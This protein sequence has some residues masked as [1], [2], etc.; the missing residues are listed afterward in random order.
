MGTLNLGQ[1]GQGEVAYGEKVIYQYHILINDQV[2]QEL[3]MIPEMKNFRVAAPE[4][5]S[6]E[7][8]IKIFDTW[9]TGLLWWYLVHN[10]PDPP[11][12]LS[13]LISVE[14]P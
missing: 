1:P 10:V 11:K 12:I 5:Y 14:P 6:G 8:D 2:G 4:K 9:I 13:E 7:D 3:Q